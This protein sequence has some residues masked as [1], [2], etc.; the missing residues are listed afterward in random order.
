MTCECDKSYITVAEADEYF[1]TRYGSDIWQTLPI[2]AKMKALVTATKRLDNLAY[3]G[4]KCNPLQKHQFPRYFVD[5][6]YALDF[7]TTAEI[8]QNIK[9]AT[10]EEALSIALFVEEYGEEAFNG[11]VN[12]NYQSMK[13]GDAQLT[14]G[15]GN[16]ANS[17]VS[18]QN[19]YGLLSDAAAK[20]LQGF[21]RTGVNIQNPMYYE[22]Y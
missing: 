7:Y 9:D 8:P 4:Y 14:Y 3:I 6:S 16:N 12:T 2:E 22:Q 18:A 17:S 19:P 21:I 1:Y 5:F 20:M 13:L 10:A 11:I 15:S